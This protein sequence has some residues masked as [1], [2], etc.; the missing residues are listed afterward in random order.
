MQDQKRMSIGSYV[1]LAAFS[2]LAA[3]GCNGSQP[4]SGNSALA[5]SAAAQTS[6]GGGGLAPLAS[7]AVPQP[8]GGDI[9]DDAAAIRLGKALF[10]DVQAGSDGQVA[11]ATCHFHAG[12]DNRRLNTLHP[13]PNGVFESGGVTS[14][15]QLFPAVNIDSDDRV[16]SQGVL[17]TTFHAVA[18]DITIAADVCDSNL[19]PIF[20]AHRLVTGRQAPSAVAA[21]FNRDNFW[22]GRGNHQFNRAN[23]FGATT[24]PGPFVENASLASQAVG[25][26]LSGTEMSCAGRTF[27]G[28]NSLGAKMMARP[29]L[30]F[31]LVSPTDSVL[32]ALSA[33]PSPGLTA[34]YSDLVAAAFGPAAAAAAVETFSSIWGQAIQAYEATLIPDR[35]PLDRFLGGDKTALTSSQQRGLGVFTGK[36]SCNK[37]HA[38]PEMTDASVS[39]AA[40]NGLVNEDGGDQGFHNL[41]VRP[42]DED[43]GR[44]GNGPAGSFS[45]SGAAS[46]HGAF[47]TPALR[48]VGLTAPYFHNGGKATLADVVDFYSRGGDFPNLEKAKRIKPL[49]L[50]SGDKA[51]LVDFLA[52]GLTDCRT[53]MDAAPFDHPSIDLPNGDSLSASGAAGNGPCP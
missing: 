27:N 30:Q 15:G 49:N 43:L 14:A 25:P 47:K 51:T 32:G 5:A 11:C 3:F 2:A 40:R 28:P 4:S 38:G 6:G 48:N 21:V 26:P 53:A 44:A 29:P 9:V 31:Q 35:T 17:S 1:A 50:A 39:F 18:T 36:G 41:G 7:A 45:V 10:W 8:A 22:D 24:S 37:C 34:S 42:T 46:D 33:W 52:N 20:G 23:P 19:D 12:A 13:G 16:G